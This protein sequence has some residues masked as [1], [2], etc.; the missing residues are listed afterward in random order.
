[1]TELGDVVESALARVGITSDRVSN[2]I[3]RPCG[4]EERKQKLNQLSAWARRVLRG[5]KDNAQKYLDE[6]LKE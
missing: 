3:G 2:W 5:K 1:M 4:C 6:I